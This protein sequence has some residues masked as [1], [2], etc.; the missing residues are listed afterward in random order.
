MQALD[1]HMNRV[2]LKVTHYTCEYCN[3]GFYGKKDYRV[4]LNRH[5][6]GVN[7]RTE[8]K[9]EED[10]NINANDLYAAL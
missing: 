2:H 6:K 1:E 5:T 10:V 9:G 3:K 7:N 4:H 8:E